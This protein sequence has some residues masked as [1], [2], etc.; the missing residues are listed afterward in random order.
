MEPTRENT[1]TNTEPNTWSGW[2]EYTGDAVALAAATKTLFSGRYALDKEGVQAGAKAA[3]LSWL[4][5]SFAARGAVS[6]IPKNAPYSNVLKGIVSLFA[7]SVISKKICP[8][9]CYLLYARYKMANWGKLGQLASYSSAAIRA[10]T[11]KKIV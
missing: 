11:G 1:I 8:H 6:Y 5:P 2:L 7:A 4:L 3:V 10:F 9:V